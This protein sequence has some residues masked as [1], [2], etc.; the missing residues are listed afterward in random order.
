MTAFPGFSRKG[1]LS[2]WEDSPKWL[3][4]RQHI[5]VLQPPENWETSVKTVGQ[6]PKPASRMQCCKAFADRA[7]CATVTSA[8][9]FHPDL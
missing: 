2:L 5:Y 3:I 4:T 7:A 6:K 1:V 9:L 8:L